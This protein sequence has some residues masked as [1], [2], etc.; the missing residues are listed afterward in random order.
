VDGAGGGPVGDLDRPGLALV[1]VALLLDIGVML[2][3]EPTPDAG[4]DGGGEVAPAVVVRVGGCV[5]LELPAEFVEAQP[6]AANS[7]P[8]ITA[9]HPSHPA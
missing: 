3:A 1:G 8:T 5:R 7:A 2:I 4:A 9:T 6:A